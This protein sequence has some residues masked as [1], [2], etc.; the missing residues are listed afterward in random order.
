MQKIII[1]LLAV[2]F[3]FSSSAAALAST[4]VST[5]NAKFIK[6]IILLEDTPP[7]EPAPTSEPSPAPEPTPAPEPEPK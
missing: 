5:G 2:V 4:G 6:Q 1:T 7:S 3:V